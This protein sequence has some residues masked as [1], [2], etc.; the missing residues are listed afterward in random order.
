MYVYRLRLRESIRRDH[1]CPSCREL[2]TTVSCMAEIL[3]VFGKT[4]PGIKSQAK[5]ADSERPASSAGTV[6]KLV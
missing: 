6:N 3:F 5:V 1:F 4:G 2:D